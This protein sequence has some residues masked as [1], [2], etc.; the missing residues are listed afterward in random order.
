MT[1]ADSSC[2]KV[3][4]KA[5]EE[6]VC[7]HSRKIPKEASVAEVLSDLGDIFKLKEQSTALKA[8]ISGKDVFA[9]LP[10]G[11]GKC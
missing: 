4:L 7:N 3:P 5:L 11:F 6:S 9:L 10:P 8:F 1:K 2:S